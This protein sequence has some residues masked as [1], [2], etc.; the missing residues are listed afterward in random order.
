MVLHSGPPGC[1]AISDLGAM[2]LRQAQDSGAVRT[3]VAF[4]DLVY[5][6]TAISLAI[7]QEGA[8]KARTGHLVGIFFDG[9]NNPPGGPGSRAAPT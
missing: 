3:D 7:E 9:L 4:G 1:A 2:L 6:I 8:S 5:V